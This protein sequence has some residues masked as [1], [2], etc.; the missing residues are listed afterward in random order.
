[1][2]RQS[3]HFARR[4]AAAGLQLSNLIDGDGLARLP[5]LTRRDLQ[6]AG[7]DLWCREVPSAHGP[8]HLA[9]TSG[10]TGEPVAIHKTGLTR[11]VWMAMTMRDHQWHER[12]L[13]GRLAGV[14]P[15]IQMP[16]RRPDWGPPAS[17]LGHTGELMLLPLGVASS[18]LVEWIVGFDPQYLLIYPSALDSITRSSRD[19]GVSLPSLRQI[20]TIGETLHPAI[21]SS[22]TTVFGV[23][24]VDCYSSREIGYL[25][26]TCPVS[27]A[28]HVMAEGVLA[29]VIA[30]DGRPCQPGQIG[31][32]TIT[33]LHNF[34]TPM[35]RYDIGDYAE[36]AP[37]CACGRGL[38]TWSRI[39][40]RDRNLIRMPD[41]TRHWPI[42]GFPRCREFAPILQYQLVQHDYESIEARL[43]VERSL[44]TSEESALRR[45]F[46]TSAGHEFT[47]RFSYFCDRIPPLGSGKFEDFVSLVSENESGCESVR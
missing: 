24:V 15:H 38:P 1:L 10:S 27:G 44:T 19:N 42:T 20:R 43:V 9:E 5:V 32:V 7:E 31:R 33:D 37:P 39:L 8:V 28:Y 40:G 26:L 2:H 34:A 45:L 18:R 47:V 6:T 3:P 11:F 25:A 29:E 23:P 14:R 13:C 16:E 35:V 17:E 22:A 4:V 46:Q 36:V 12:D 30:D 41:G 21:R